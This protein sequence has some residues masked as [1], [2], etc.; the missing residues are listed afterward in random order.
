MNGNV[1]CNFSNFSCQYLGGTLVIGSYG[2]CE[3]EQT[4]AWK[5]KE[6]HLA[7]SWHR[8]FPA[9]VPS[10]TGAAV[11]ESGKWKDYIA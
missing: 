7:K 3:K 10:N 2:G 6:Y 1:A 4:K 9:A 8:G 11:G 5:E